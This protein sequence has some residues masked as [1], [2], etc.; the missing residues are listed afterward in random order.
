MGSACFFDLDLQV[1]R[2]AGMGACGPNESVLHESAIA[3]RVENHA[4]ACKLR[5]L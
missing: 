1:Q 2:K 3:F 5:K 4:V